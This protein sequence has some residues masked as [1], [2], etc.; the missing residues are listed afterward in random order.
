MKRMLIVLVL[1]SML[2]SACTAVAPAAPA[3][4][5]AAEATA[6]AAEEAAAPA[7]DVTYVLV[8]KNLG[9]PYFD[10]AN[11]GAQEAA[12][13]LGVTVLYQGSSTA[14]ATEQI[15]LI[16]SLI[17]QQVQRFRRPGSRGQGSHCRRHPRGELGFRHCP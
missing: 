11:T 13:E 6:A 3:A 12:A 9:N 4:D 7:G 5:V 10:A 1:L 8:P 14:D 17:A 2:L 16:N 15:Q